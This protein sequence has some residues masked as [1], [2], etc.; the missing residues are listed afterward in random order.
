MRKLWAQMG[1]L[2]KQ[3]QGEKHQLHGNTEE[4]KFSEPV[5]E[6]VL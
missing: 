4:A 6:S 3:K 1:L 2:G 5:E